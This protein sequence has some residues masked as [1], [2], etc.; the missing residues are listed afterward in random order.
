M[1]AD[2]VKSTNSPCHFSSLSC[3]KSSEFCS[4][5]TYSNIAF[6]FSSKIVNLI[7]GPLSLFKDTDFVLF[8][9][10]TNT[11]FLEGEL[12]SRIKGPGCSDIILGMHGDE[13]GDQDFYRVQN[14]GRDWNCVLHHVWLII[15]DGRS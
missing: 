3:I 9:Y 6:A 2:G 10:L 7:L 15:D 1:Y 11:S 5:I 8:P 4:V 13:E 14:Q 12:E